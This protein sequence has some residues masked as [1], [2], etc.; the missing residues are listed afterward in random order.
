[1][2]RTVMRKQIESFGTVRKQRDNS[3][4]LGMDTI[5]PRCPYLWPVTGMDTSLK[6]L[7]DLLFPYRFT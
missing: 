6:V 5:D 4:T 2:H 7:I 1:M 3:S